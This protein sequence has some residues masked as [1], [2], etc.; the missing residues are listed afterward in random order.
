MIDRLP[1]A[2]C[3][4]A[5]VTFVDVS[6]NVIKNLPRCLDKNEALVELRASNNKIRK[7]PPKLADAPNILKVLSILLL[8]SQGCR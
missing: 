1:N 7:P 3:E 2:M 8:I 5:K 6:D 4:L